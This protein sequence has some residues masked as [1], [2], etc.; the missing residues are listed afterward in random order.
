MAAIGDSLT[1]GFGS[2]LALTSCVR[3]SWSTGDGFRVDSHFRRILDGSP[4][5]RGHAYNLAVPGAR[6]RD[7]DRQ[8][9]TAVARRPA[10]VTVLVGANDACRASV[11]AMTPVAA[12]RAD[13][14]RALATLGRGLPRARVLVVSVPDLYQVWQVGR[15]NRSAVRAWNRGVCPSLLAR[16]TSTAE[17]DQRR[18]QAVRDRVEAYNAALAAACRAYGPRCRTDGGAAHR[19]RITLDM[20]TG[21]DYFHP[22]VDGLNELAD[23][24]YPGTFTW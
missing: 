14:D 2:C 20:V 4:A 6:A 9:Q 10:Y 13:V 3:N 8:A 23:V 22:D 5:I 16:P 12:F 24:T 18:R 1:S 11:D 7:L 15:A 19:V 17:A 21:L